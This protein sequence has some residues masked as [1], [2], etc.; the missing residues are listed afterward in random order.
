MP[1]LFSVITPSRGDRPLALGQAI[2]SVARALSHVAGRLGPEGL[3]MLVG[4]DGRKGRRVSEAPFVRWFDFPGGGHFG[5]LVR[6]SL[7]RQAR[8]QRLILLDDDNALTLQALDVFLDHPEEMVIGRVDTSRAFDVPFLPRD[9][10]GRE[11]VRPGN[12]DPL[13]LCLSRDLVAHR[14]RGWRDEGGYESDFLNIRRYH[15]RARSVAVVSD[16]VGVYDA[17][18]GLDEGGR[19]ARQSRAG[20]GERDGGEGRAGAV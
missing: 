4:F 10:P 3:E 20:P 17:G 9:E 15:R 1:V 2:D 5:N 12:V 13:C 19:N 6:D 8:G 14:G 7:I 11:V 18:R 16:L